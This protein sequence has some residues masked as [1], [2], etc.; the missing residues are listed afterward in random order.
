MILKEKALR[1]IPNRSMVCSEK[2]LGLSDE[3]EGVILMHDGTDHAGH[4]PGTPLQDVLGDVLLDIELTPNLARCFSM[5]GVARE[6]AALLGKE[7]RYPS[8]DYLAEGPPIAGH[9]NASTSASRN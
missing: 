5:L 4:A 1:G 3:H 7:L 2:E 8:Y 6:V 9:C